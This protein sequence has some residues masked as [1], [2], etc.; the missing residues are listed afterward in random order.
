MVYNSVY[1]PSLGYGTPAM[2]LS[3]Q[4]FEEIQRADMNAILPKM[5]ISQSAPMAV[6]FGTSQ[7]V[8]LGLTHLTSLQGHTKLQDIFGHLRCG[9]ASG[10]I[11]QMLL[12]YTQLGCGCCGNPLEQDYKK[13]LELLINTN[14]ITEVWEHLHTCNATVEVMGCGNQ[15]PTDI[16]IL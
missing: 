12:E 6:V 13:Y 14:W 7:F 4:D 5:G 3:Y 10:R 8:G 2:T 15:K 16:T 1:M 9:Y 11:M